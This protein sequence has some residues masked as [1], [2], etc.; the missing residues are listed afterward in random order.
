MCTL[1]WCWVMSRSVKNAYS[2]GASAVTTDSQ[3][4]SR[5]AGL[6][7]SRCDGRVPLTTALPF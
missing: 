4:G 7:F 3:G 2:V 5:G 1:A 6:D